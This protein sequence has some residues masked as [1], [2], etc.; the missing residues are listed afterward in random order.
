MGSSKTP[1]V[2]AV[3]L[4]YGGFGE[5]ERTLC[6]ITEQ[7][8]PINTVIV[9]DDASGE[10]FSSALRKRFCNAEFRVNQKNLG[11]VAHMNVLAAQVESDYIK[12]LAGGDAFSDPHALESLVTFAARL[13]THVVT[14]QSM[15]C[16]SSLRR[17]LYPFP[18]KRAKKLEGTG[19]E[20]FRTLACANLISAPG[21]LFRRSF[22]T[23]LGGFDESYHLLEDWP[24]WLRLT[25]EGHGI[26]YLDRVTCLHSV[27]G[28][29]SKH[30][31]AHHAPQ[32]KQDMLLCYEKELLPF[33][34]R[35]S[36]NEVKRLRYGY[37]VVR[38]LSHAELLKKYGWL[39]RRAVWKRSVKGCLL[40]LCRN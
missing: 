11:T 30:L 18:G 27:G 12:F 39:E 31:D 13:A 22:F 35:F 24:A 4:T 32:L 2:T 28:V 23:Q 3:V 26:L 1:S 21:T 14:S 37:D 17:P 5:L 20:Q 15:I 40:E 9:S 33:L 10:K 25:R 16:T 36:Q 6:S 34:N 7:T 38:G 29:S 8:Y 19:P